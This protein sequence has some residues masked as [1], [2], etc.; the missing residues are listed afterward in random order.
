MVWFS[1]D[2][3]T[4]EMICANFML[5]LQNIPLEESDEG[6]L[7]RPSAQKDGKDEA[8]G[9]SPTLKVQRDVA[10]ILAPYF[11]SDGL[12]KKA[13]EFAGES[14]EHIMDFT[15]LRALGSLFSMLNQAVRN[16]LQYNHT[17]ADFPIMIEH[18]E[19]YM[20]KM[21]VNA[22]LW[23][24]AGDAKMKNRNEMSDFVRSATTIPLP[25]GNPNVPILDYEV[26][27]ATGEWLPWSNKVPQ[28]EVETHKVASPDVVVPTLDTVRHEA[29]LYTWLADHKP[30]GESK[31]L[32]CLS[33]KWCHSPQVPT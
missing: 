26:A 23:S 31:F 21:L 1:E 14:L 25:P 9:V 24:F 17:H 28:M 19:K 32:H 7:F 16:V 13:L 22:V 6:D 8:D 30:M 5:R 33:V 27:I 10:S 3:L 15:R 29:L 11:A 2:V 20:S 18:L 12:V 4:T